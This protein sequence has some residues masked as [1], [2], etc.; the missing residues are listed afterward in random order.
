MNQIT[1]RRFER[2]VAE[3]PFRFERFEAKPIR[4][5]RALSWGPLREFG[6]AIVRCTLVRKNDTVTAAAA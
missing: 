5:L 6:T 4:G 2:I 1:I 3:S